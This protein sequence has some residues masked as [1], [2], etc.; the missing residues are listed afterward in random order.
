M[1]IPNQMPRIRCFFLGLALLLT[2]VP[3]MAQLPPHFGQYMFNNTI[4]NPAAAG[5]QDVLHA[6]LLVRRQWAGFS[7]APFTGTI[8]LDAPL[9]DERNNLGMIFTHDRI[10]VARQTSLQGQYAFRFD[11][12]PGRLG[13][14]LQGGLRMRRL[15]FSQVFTE[16]PGDVVFADDTPLLTI[17]QVGFGAWYE[18][19]IFYAGFSVPELLRLNTSAYNVWFADE[20]WYRHAFLTGGALIDLNYDFKLKPSILVKYHPSVPVQVDINASIIMRQKLWFGLG[21]RTNGAF[22]GLLQFQANEQLRIGYAYELS[23]RE[24]MPWNS[25]THGFVVSYDF[26]YS[27]NTAR[28]GYF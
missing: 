26:G 28:P 1:M 4:L 14:G 2:G 7:G 9:R 17:P 18:T 27:I 19:N 23:T 15:R 6:T 5:S 16:D 25:G 13:L 8:S 22:L 24:L 3:A 11:L 21:Y 12:G 10:G 20:L